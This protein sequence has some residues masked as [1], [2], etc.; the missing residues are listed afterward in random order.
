MYYSIACS[1][2]VTVALMQNRLNEL[3]C[4]GYRNAL[5]LF[6]RER[7]VRRFK[8]NYRAQITGPQIYMRFQVKGR[9]VARDFVGKPAEVRRFSFYIFVAS[10]SQG[11]G[12]T[13]ST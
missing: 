6:D 12:E 3:P 13:L 1:L 4:A 5:S 8:L 10:Q 9:R 7:M 2:L 11:A